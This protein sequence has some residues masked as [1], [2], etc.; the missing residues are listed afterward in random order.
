MIFAQYHDIVIIVILV[1]ESLLSSACLRKIVIRPTR[2]GGR[3]FIHFQ[4]RRHGRLLP[5]Q[6]FCEINEVVGQIQSPDYEL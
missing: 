3:F 5:M 2:R 6:N 1:V 4:G